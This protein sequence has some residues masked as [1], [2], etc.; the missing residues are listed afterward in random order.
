MAVHYRT[1]GIILKK[2]E[3]GEADQ[4]FTIYT[5]DF[6]RLN[7]LGKGIR[8][9]SSKLRAGIEIFYLS[10]IEFIQGKAHKTLTDALLIDRFNSLRS[11]LKRLNIAFK[12]AK[13]LDRFTSK[14]EPDKKI[15]QLLQETLKKLDD[16]K[17]K[18]YSLELIYYYFLW[19][20]FSVLGYQPELSSCLFCGKKISPGLV[21]FDS[22]EGGLI[23]SS[24][25]QKNPSRETKP[26]S[27]DLIKILRIILKKDW[28]IIVRLRFDSSLK[29]LDEIS[30]IYKN[31]L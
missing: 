31:K 10:E 14:Q 3:R 4:L 26:I 18:I 9:I 22:D 5:K 20:L 24:C 30:K 23:C 21:Y 1:L 12:I 7:I 2:T 19:N 28:G 27:P 11:D 13:A 25:F 17:L 15:W 6:G 16:S 29:Q 8:K